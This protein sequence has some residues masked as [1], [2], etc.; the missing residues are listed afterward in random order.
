[1]PKSKKR[2]LIGKE[3][4][5]EE[6][7]I[8]AEIR[9]VSL[10]KLIEYNLIFFIPVFISV[11][12]CAA[13][14]KMVN[15]FLQVTPKT[16]FSLLLVPFLTII[17]LFIIPYIRRHEKKAGFR[18]VVVGFLIVGIFMAVPAMTRGD[19]G[20]LLDHLMFIAIFLTLT[21]IYSPE[22]L[23][24]TSDIR[25]WFKHHHQITVVAVYLVILL[26]FLSGFAWNYY[27]IYN[28]P[29]IPDQFNIP[30]ENPGYGTFFYY[31]A[32]TFATV[33]YGE[34]TPVGAAAKIVAVAEAIVS[35]VLNVLFIAI[36]LL[37]I[38]NVQ[39]LSAKK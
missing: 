6:R 27:K 14:S 1:M 18:M 26:S 13:L 5:A 9:Q 24:I 33:G 30:V 15:S 21:F 17:F 28:D 12:V 8:E 16:A 29:T 25:E 36:L 22:V 32:I 20:M 23:G 19:F 37:Y 34:I 4:K 3:I 10:N 7:K 2:G 31:S 35:T 39:V 11:Y 38:S